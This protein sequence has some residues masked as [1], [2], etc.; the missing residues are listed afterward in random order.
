M[1]KPC[2]RPDTPRWKW[3]PTSPSTYGQ[4][5][6]RPA[7]PQRPPG[8]FQLVVASEKQGPGTKKRDFVPGPRDKTHVT[9]LVTR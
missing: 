1:L 7:R 9:G 5:L 2:M 6:A 4:G 3:M 8:T